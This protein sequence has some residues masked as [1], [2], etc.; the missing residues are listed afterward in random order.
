MNDK[1]LRIPDWLLKKTD[2]SPTEKMVY[3]FYYSYTFYGKMGCCR[4]INEEICYRLG[5]SKR[6]LQ[7]AKAE[8]KKDKYIETDGGIMVKA[9][10]NE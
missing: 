2:L 1:D 7:Y 5:I 9:L 4:I 6:T 8:L 3:A 10:V